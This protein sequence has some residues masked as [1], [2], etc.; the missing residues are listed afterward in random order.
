MV[1]GMFEKVWLASGWPPQA[2]KPLQ[3]KQCILQKFHKTNVVGHTQQ[4]WFVL[5]NFLIRPLLGFL[6]PFSYYRDRAIST[7]FTFQWAGFLIYI[8]M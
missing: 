3:A 2:I 6:E 8:N 7:M 5:S 1:F 4:W